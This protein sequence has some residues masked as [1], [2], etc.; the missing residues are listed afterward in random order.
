MVADTV[1]AVVCFLL[2]YSETL[3]GC[4][5]DLAGRGERWSGRCCP[6]AAHAGEGCWPG[7]HFPQS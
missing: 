4:I 6:G 1:N 5:C 7:F 2:S 3:P